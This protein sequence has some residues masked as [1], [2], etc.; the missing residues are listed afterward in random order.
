MP[1]TPLNL[2]RAILLAT[3]ILSTTVL[4]QDADTVESASTTL[5]WLGALPVVGTSRTECDF[6]YKTILINDTEYIDAN[7]KISD[8]YVSMKSFYIYFSWYNG[9]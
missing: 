2:L 8:D 9:T 4:S 1:R 3:A 6:T 7:V 5:T